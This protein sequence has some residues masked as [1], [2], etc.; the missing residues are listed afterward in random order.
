MC[1][2]RSHGSHLCSM[3]TDQFSLWQVCGS[4]KWFIHSAICIHTGCLQKVLNNVEFD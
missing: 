4:S 1:I 2:A 3:Q